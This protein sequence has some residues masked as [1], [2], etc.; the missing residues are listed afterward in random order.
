MVMNKKS[1][2][3]YKALLR[4]EDALLAVYLSISCD[5]RGIADKDKRRAETERQFDEFLQQ[6]YE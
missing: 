6:V 4:Q 1:R 3:R 5:N 2:K